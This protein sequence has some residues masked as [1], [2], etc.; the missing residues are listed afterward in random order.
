[1]LFRSIGFDN[2]K[3]AIQ[4]GT[5]ILDGGEIGS[6]SSTMAIFEIEKETNSDADASILGEIHLNYKE[7]NSKVKNQK[8]LDIPVPNSRIDSTDQML[9]F[10]TSLT[11]FGLKLKKSPYI[12]NASWT[13][14]KKYS[15]KVLDTS[16]VNQVQFVALLNKAIDIYEP[17]K[18]KKKRKSK[19]QPLTSAILYFDKNRITLRYA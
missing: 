5:S 15:E 13:E 9:K 2:N 8:Q 16:N 4:N 14:V 1:M 11:F 3:D 10:A 19:K 18:K 12:N 6:G 17:S 7:V